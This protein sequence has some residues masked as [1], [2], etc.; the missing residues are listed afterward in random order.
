MATPPTSLNF[1]RDAREIRL[2]AAHCGA[3]KPVAVRYEPRNNR[4]DV[5]FEIA[6]EAGT[7][8]TRLRFSGTAIETVEAAVLARSV[9]RGE[10][11][12]IP[13]C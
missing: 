11:L 7:A 8:A 6:N 5:T 12:K 13:T 1:D 10:I 3:L 4:F 2:D 9:E